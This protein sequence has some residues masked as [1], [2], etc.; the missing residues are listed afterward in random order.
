MTAVGLFLCYSLLRDFYV[1]RSEA[2]RTK[3]AREAM[4]LLNQAFITRN[5]LWIE[6]RWDAIAGIFGKI[7]QYLAKKHL[8]T[9]GIA[10]EAAA[11]IGKEHDGFN[12]ILLLHK[13]V[14]L[15]QVFDF[16]G[17]VVLIDKVDDPSNQQLSRSDG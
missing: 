11:L 8:D 14:D 6:R 4:L 12:S 9:P 16:S 2:K 15:A 10:S 5:R 17:V 7:V 3:S 13:L 1:D